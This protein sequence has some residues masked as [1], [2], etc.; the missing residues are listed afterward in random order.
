M[1]TAPFVI[2]HRGASGYLPEHTLEAKALAHGMG[3]DYIE[4]DI[5]ATR[6][7]VLIVLHDIDLDLVTDVAEKFPEHRRSDGHYYAIDFT[8]DEIKT[9]G[10][11]ERRHPDRNEAFFAGRFP[12]DTLKFSIPTLD[13]ELALI[14]GLNRSTGRVAGIYP[15]LKNP[16][17]H[18]DH[19]IDLARK[20]LATLDRFG[21]RAF[22]DDAIVQCFDDDELR[23]VR[24]ELGSHLKLTQLLEGDDDTSRASFERI[25]EYANGVGLPYPSLIAT[26][27]SA[28]SPLRTSA[29]RSDLRSSGLFV[30]PYTLRRDRLP[31]F[32]TDFEDL[33]RFLFADVK[34]DGLFCDHPDVARAVRDRSA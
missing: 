13:E 30:H 28:G 10:V 23:R 25:A 29:V 31:A 15:E 5:V 21:Y 22:D 16:K 4:Q 2:A 7:G 27:Q 9:L 32:A 19:G 12:R 24:E 11:L 1:P 6:D 20:L 26:P 8:L 18:A 3:A 33:L 14:Q 34:V 17:W